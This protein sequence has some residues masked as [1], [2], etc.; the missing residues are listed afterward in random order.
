MSLSLIRL[1]GPLLRFLACEFAVFYLVGFGSLVVLLRFQGRWPP[2]ETYLLT[3]IL[4]LAANIVHAV[5]IGI[6]GF[7][8]VERVKGYFGVESFGP[9]GRAF[10]ADARLRAGVPALIRAVDDLLESYEVDHRDVAAD[11]ATWRLHVLGY[12]FLLS[13]QC[14][15]AGT[16]RIEVKPVSQFIRSYLQVAE[17]TGAIVIA[18]VLWATNGLGILQVDVE[19]ETTPQWLQ[20]ALKSFY[21][22]FWMTRRRGRR[23]GRRP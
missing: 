11:S 16:I 7:L 14:L 3:A 1:V 22:P 6:P 18:S 4:A 5:I 2:E 12:R 20:Q 9:G 23:L 10:R 8:T 21:E 13:A 17:E 19:S 15:G